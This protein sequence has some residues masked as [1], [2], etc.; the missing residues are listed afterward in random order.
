MHFSV[1]LDINGRLL[2]SLSCPFDE[3]V[4]SGHTTA[5][6]HCALKSPLSSDKLMIFLMAGMQLCNTC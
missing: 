1:T 4:M 5:D 2:T 6:F 3:D